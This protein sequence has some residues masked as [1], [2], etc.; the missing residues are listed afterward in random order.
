MGIVVGFGVRLLPV[1]SG[2][3]LQTLIL[4]AGLVLAGAV[5]YTLSHAI[6]KT[7]FFTDMTGV[8]KNLLS[9]RLKGLK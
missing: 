5:I 2:G 4:T 6:M 1:M 7:M 8:I 3:T 9:G